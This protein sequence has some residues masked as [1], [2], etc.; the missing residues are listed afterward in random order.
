MSSEFEV[1]VEQEIRQVS[2]ER[3]HVVL[4]GAG[5]SR[6]TCPDGDKN[7]RA[8]PLMSDF[9]EVLGLRS[10]LEGWNVD[11]ER[12]F[13]EIFSE[14][15]EKGQTR[16]IEQIQN[17]VKGYFDE[18]ELPERPTIYDHLVLSLR[19]EDLIATFN[20]DPLLM[21]AYARSSRAGMMLPLLAF[22][23]GN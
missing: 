11:A 6:A 9:V 15:W 23:H 4:L 20:W 5:A 10:I 21:Q 3:S 17:A 13:E 16:K 19:R 12:N 22:L 7:G 2:M 14:L 18:L 8:L 1:S